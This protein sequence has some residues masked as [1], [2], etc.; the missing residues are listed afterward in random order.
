MTT[1]IKG[2]VGNVIVQPITTGAL[3]DGTTV[4]TATFRATAPNGGNVETWTAS[5]E[6]P[7]ATSLTLAYTLPAPLSRG[8]WS[9]RPF[10]YVGGVLV[11]SID[12]DSQRIQV[13]PDIVPPP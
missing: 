2:E 8:V 1:I 5:I 7:T 10:L 6:S 9:V 3:L 13:T 11:T 4:T 12:L